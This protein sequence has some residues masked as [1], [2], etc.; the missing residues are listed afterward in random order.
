MSF[1]SQRFFF[2]VSEQERLQD[3]NF[4]CLLQSFQESCQRQAA[5]ICRLILIFHFSLAPPV[6]QALGGPPRLVFWG[7]P[8]VALTL[9]CPPS[10]SVPSKPG[11]GSRPAGTAPDLLW[12][13]VV[14]ILP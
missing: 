1:F 10:P 8:V 4:S 6:C 2:P 7:I 9:L 3:N 5:L 13:Q 12:V 14:V 11:T